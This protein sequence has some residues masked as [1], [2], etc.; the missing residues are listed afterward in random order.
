ME[1]K[2]GVMSKQ[3]AVELTKLVDE[4]VHVKLSGGREGK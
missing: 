1:Q 3:S 2:R 4:G